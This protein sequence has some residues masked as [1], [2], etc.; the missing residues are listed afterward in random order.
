MVL[1]SVF[2]LTVTCKTYVIIRFKTKSPTYTVQVEK[3]KP[4]KAQ[5]TCQLPPGYVKVYILNCKYVYLFYLRLSL[6]TLS[7]YTKIETVL[8][9]TEIVV[10][11]KMSLFLCKPDYLI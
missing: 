8:I 6:F 11:D 2:Q 1:Y 4:A 3:K 10:F 5:Y 7:N 9:K